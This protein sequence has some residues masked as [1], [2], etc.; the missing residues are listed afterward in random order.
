MKKN[1]NIF[2]KLDLIAPYPKV[3]IF[4]NEKY[5][6]KFS[7]I[8]SIIIIIISILFSIDLII[9]FFEYD[10][11]TI[12]Y[13]KN[14]DKSIERNIL[15]KDS[16]LLFGLFENN[17]FNL[18]DESIA[19]FEAKYAIE[20][21]NISQ[22]FQTESLKLEK[23]EFGKNID[24]KYKNNSNNIDLNNFY[25]ISKK[26]E[27]LPLFYN[28][29]IGKSVIYLYIYLKEG[30][31]YT[32]DDL[33][34]N[35]I[36]GNDIIDNNNKNNPI[37]NSYFT[38]QYFIFSSSNFNIIYYYLQFIKYESDIGL[39]SPNK[40][41]FN[42]KSFSHISMMESNFIP[43]L[44]KSQ[45][46]TV[47]ISLSDNNFD[48]YKRVYP[49]IQSLIAEI[50]SFIN[51]LFTIGEFI[52]NFLLNKMMSKSIVKYLLNDSKIFKM[53][54][55]EIKLKNKNNIKITEL[56]ELSEKEI[57]ENIE[58]KSKTEKNTINT[59]TEDNNNINTVDAGL[60]NNKNSNINNKSLNGLN[61]FHIIKSFLCCKDKKV[62]LINL[63]EDF[64]NDNLSIELIIERF[65][66]IENKLSN[67]ININSQN[68]QRNKILEDIFELIYQV[69][70]K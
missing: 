40:K 70:Q 67:I 1:E 4:S 58:I 62:K 48:Y 18:V 14:N 36:N 63:C 8:L 68:S 3:K 25:C 38:S 30:S 29:D 35:I 33:F 57:D 21:N 19:Y 42:A 47:L 28:P 20:Y 6:S 11:P 2:Y 56:K 39:F 26:H 15:I 37:S 55:E 22:D 23:C 54:N 59:T 61:Y 10:S 60:K 51:L 45:I 66:E 41:Y 9:N 31:N 50:T 46:G 69:E 32:A 12:V 17:N 44:K 16:L 43:Q 49:R 53:K 64:I 27:N 65:Y 24:I 13:S 5:K 34:L 7:T 52:S